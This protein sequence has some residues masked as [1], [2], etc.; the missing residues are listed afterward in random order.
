MTES[1][2]ILS[3][4]IGYFWGV[5]AYL[6]QYSIFFLEFYSKNINILFYFLMMI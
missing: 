6:L 2:Y 3:I 5:C 1:E 4:N